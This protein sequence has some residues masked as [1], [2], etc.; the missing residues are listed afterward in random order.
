MAKALIVATSAA[1]W[2]AFLAMASGADWLEPPFVVGAALS[3]LGLL[4]AIAAG[5]RGRRFAWV[6]VAAEI[7]AIGWLIL[8]CCA[9]WSEGSGPIFRL[10]ELLHIPIEP[11]TAGAL[12][13]P[14]R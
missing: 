5:I 10:L 14:D 4:V 8:A 12:A 7:V 1:P 13:L 3:P 6:Y 2:M 11:A 9:A